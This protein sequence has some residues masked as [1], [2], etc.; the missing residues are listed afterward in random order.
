MIPDQFH[1][2]INYQ[3]S[4]PQLIEQALTH[5]SYA[6][7]RHNERLEFLGDSVLNL[8]ISAYI[9]RQFPDAREGE[10]SRLRASLVKEDTLAGMARELGIG[11]YLRLGGGELKSGGYRRPSILADALEAVIGAVYLDADFARAE[12]MVLE[13]Y[14]SRLQNLDIR[15]EMKDPKTRLQEF[16][17]AQGSALPVYIIEQTTGQSHNQ[18][19][20]ASCQ[21]VEL[22]LKAQGRGSSRK[23]AE[24]RAAQLLLDQ[25]GI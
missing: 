8:V 22:E 4:D 16:L 19:F 17:Q 12:T 20:T 21:I 25:L 6:R 23:K 15:Q 14:R 7:T 1:R 11:D 3:F 13:L 5:R 10:L 18:I 24:Q 2:L 9:Y